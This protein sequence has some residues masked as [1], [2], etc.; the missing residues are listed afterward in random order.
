M[1]ELSIHRV[2]KVTVS[3]EFF[4]THDPNRDDF[5]VVRIHIHSDSGYE[6]V[7]LYVTQEEEPE[8]NME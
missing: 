5:W 8:I 2:N 4:P 1:A 6:E 3:K 7:T